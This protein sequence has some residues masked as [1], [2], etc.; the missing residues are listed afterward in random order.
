MSA[1]GMIICVEDDRTEATTR[2]AADPD[3][4]RIIETLKR[5]SRRCDLQAP[6]LRRITSQVTRLDAV[7]VFDPREAEP[8]GTRAWRT[9][10]T[11]T[12]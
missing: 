11:A 10:E 5:V 7:F 8:A 12:L 1:D 9:D 6:T 2:L 3:M 4:A